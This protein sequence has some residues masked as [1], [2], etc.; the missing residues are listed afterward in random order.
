MNVSPGWQVCHRSL[1]RIDQ[2]QQPDVKNSLGVPSNQTYDNC[3]TAVFVRMRFDDVTSY[4]QDI[5]YVL[6]KGLRVV[7]Y[8]GLDDVSPSSCSHYCHCTSDVAKLICNYIGEE[9]L[10]N[11]MPWSGQSAFNEAPEMA[12]LVDGVQ[13][14]TARSADNLSFLKIEN[15]GHM[16]PMG[17]LEAL[18]GSSLGLTPRRP[19]CGGP[20][21]AQLFY[22][23]YSIR[24]CSRI[25]TNTLSLYIS[26]QLAAKLSSCRCTS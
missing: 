19:A 9:T 18:P 25:A 5:A 22:Q 7:S 20:Q 10:Y 3:N 12:Y 2:C 15:A 8:N 21:L 26:C 24:N 16:V 23:R 17:A 6:E 1:M 4:R 11:E 13:V 14:G